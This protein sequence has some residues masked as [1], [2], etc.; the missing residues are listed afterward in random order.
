MPQPY[1]GKETP[2]FGP[3]ALLERPD[4][5]AYIA[6]VS[7]SWETVEEAWGIILAI[8]LHADARIGVELYYSLT[9]SSAQAT[10]LKRA[11]EISAEGDQQVTEAFEKLVRLDKP[12]AKERNRIVHGR[13]GI[14][15]SNNQ[16]LILGETRWLPKTMANLPRLHREARERGVEFTPPDMPMSVY[17]KDDFKA[18]LQRISELAGEQ[19]LFTLFLE[20]RRA[21]QI[22]EVLARAQKPRPRSRPGLLGGR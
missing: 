15:P 18:V 3:E 22:Q 4:L 7:T 8:A 17:K 12:R 13:W 10:V 19:H 16:V 2:V 14:L 20:K 9:G 6:A 21:R 11:V 1:R 5:A